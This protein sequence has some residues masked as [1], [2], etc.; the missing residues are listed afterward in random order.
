M[1]KYLLAIIIIALIVGAAYFIFKF[2][3]GAKP[4]LAPST[5]ISPK[6]WT[7]EYK[8]NIFIPKE[9]KIKKGD[10][11]TWI[12]NSLESPV[13]PASAFHP[14]HNVYPGFDALKSLGNGESYSFKFDIVGSWKYHDH[15]N[16]SVTGVVVVEE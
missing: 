15:L 11:V 10:T 13:W 7:V 16:P 1:K 3:S 9:I 8:E 6:T 4:V 14:T 2:Y 12:N 5:A